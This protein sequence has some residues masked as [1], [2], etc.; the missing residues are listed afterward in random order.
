MSLFLSSMFLI[1][2]TTFIFLLID[3]ALPFQLSE[4]FL[5]YTTLVNGSTY[6]KTAQSAPVHLNEIGE[7]MGFFF[8][9]LWDCILL[10]QRLFLA[11]QN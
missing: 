1:Y 11:S 10:S 8:L 3:C 2:S 5:T 4:R 7:I 9:V 6:I